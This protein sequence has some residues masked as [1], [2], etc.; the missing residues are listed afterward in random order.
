M[1]RTTNPPWPRVIGLSAKKRHGKDTLG[2]LLK[3]YGY[4]RIAF[5]DALYAEV[6][7]RVGVP[8]DV[9]KNAHFKER[10]MARLDGRS[11]RAVLQEYGMA[12]RQEDPDYWIR[13]VEQALRAASPQQRWVITDVRLPNEAAWVEERGVLVR[14]IRPA[15]TAADNHISET[16]LDSWVFHYR[17]INNEGDPSGM[18]ES[19]MRQLAGGNK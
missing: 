7:T 10:P 17:V 11:P 14:V 19:L 8:V 3:P 16:A 2:Q 1:T 18:L 6:A 15:I 9:L 12:K 5:A 13:Q 4:R